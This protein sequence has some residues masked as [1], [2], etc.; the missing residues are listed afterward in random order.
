[1]QTSANPATSAFIL[2]AGTALKDR[3]PMPKAASWESIPR[4]LDPTNG[5]FI[6]DGVGWLWLVAPEPKA[7]G[8]GRGSWRGMTIGNPGLGPGVVWS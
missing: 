1:V 3:P 5:A 4:D 6:A 8:T 2:M 7:P